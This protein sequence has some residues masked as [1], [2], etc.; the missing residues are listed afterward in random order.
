M[1]LLKKI[2][3][4]FNIYL[5]KELT[6]ILLLS[7]GILTFILVLSRLGKI[8]DLVIN[9]GVGF[10]DIFALVAFS[11]P[12]Y[13]TFTLPMAFLLSVIVV[14]GRLSTENEILALKASGVNLKW[15]FVPI[16]F[17]G[18]IVTTLGLVNTNILLPRCSGLFRETLINVI[19][20]GISVDD[21]EGVFNDS[22]PGVVIYI[23]KVDSTKRTLTGIVVSDERNKDVKQTISASK[24]YVNIDSDTFELYFMLQD[25]TLHRWE[26]ATDTYRS[27]N[28]QNYTFTMNL[29]QMVQTG[30]I[31]RKLAY[32]MD[33]NELKKALKTTKNEDNRYDLLLEI[34]KKISLPLSSLAFIILTVPLG[35]KRKVEG[36]FSGTLYSLLLFIFYYVLIAMTDSLGKNIHAPP[37]I[38]TFLPNVVIM[39]MGLY[40]LRSLN[41]E[42]HVTIS[43][44]LKYLWVYCLEKVK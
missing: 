33:R 1:K 16:T 40:L 12:P 43:Q 2:P 22:V 31:S 35:V 44:R 10:G 26:K 30:G 25:G 27:V 7:L 8:A 42:E 20:K 15:L 23:N 41:K 28:F 4:K 39:T 34:Y 9:K 6:G 37:Y 32:E 3:L 11:V 13:L 38:V 18:L 19:K 5:L 21:K 14:L 36:R 29:S 17:V 24:G